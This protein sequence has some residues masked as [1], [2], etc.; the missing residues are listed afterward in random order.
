MSDKIKT[1][2]DINE[3]EWTKILRESNWHRDYEQ[4]MF[5]R[6]LKADNLGE[7]NFSDYRC[8]EAGSLVFRYCITEFFDE[9]GLTVERVIQTGND[10]EYAPGFSNVEYDTDKY[11]SCLLNGVYFISKG[12][13]RFI[14]SLEQLHEGYLFKV[15]SNK[16]QAWTSARL[17]EQFLE[18]G[19]NHNFLKGKKIDAACNFIKFDRDYTWDDLILTPSLKDEIRQNLSN[20]IDFRHVYQANNLSIKRGLIFS[21]PPGCGKSTLGKILCKNISWTFIWVTPKYLLHPKHI[22][23]IVD[24]A[25]ELSPSV[26]FLED[27]DLY[28]GQRE[29]NSNVA[30]LGE[31]MNQLDGIQ[32]NKDIITLA[33]TN[34]PDIMEKALIDRPGRFDKVLKFD[35][36]DTE[37]RERMLTT[38]AKGIH[39]DN[40]DMAKVAKLTDKLTGAHLKELVN[41]AV[42]H[43]ID[44]KSYD[45]DTHV[46][47]LKKEHMKEALKSVKAKDFGKAIGITS[48]DDDEG[49]C[50]DDD[51]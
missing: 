32:E 13:D 11:K 12:D 3:Q 8:S 4:E 46:I 7:V 30:L 23:S 16:N 21:G 18:Y 45:P 42:I 9:Q 39:L 27:I 6:F 25:K 24:L 50:E 36:P 26:L 1:T 29:T 20:L 37:C 35:K 22:A 49:C 2:Q 33:T 17:I 40:I 48:E 31:L 44:S 51:I 14:F 38:F 41:L 5:K 15:A 43:A 47:L 19:R 10:G 34:K 28:G